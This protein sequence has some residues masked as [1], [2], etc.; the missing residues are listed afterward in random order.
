MIALFFDTET[1]GFINPKNP[2]E[3][4]Q[5]AAILEDTETRR[6][7]NQI[8]LIVKPS[9]P[10]PQE[11][12]DIHGITDELAAR[13]GVRPEI[14]D[15]MLALLAAQAD[16]IVAHNIGFDV[17]MVKHAWTISGPIMETKKQYCTMRNCSDYP[18][19][20]HK[21]AGR[22]QFTKLADAYQYFF[23]EGFGDAHNAMADTLACQRLYY[24]LLEDEAP[25]LV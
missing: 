3:I 9:K 11:V 17:P 8:N 22:S 12:I 20:P 10:I 24:R 5:I 4:V 7:L 1:T 16:R 23:G 15:N 19:I 14:A 13:H 25:A 2:A 21:H 6:V 18:E